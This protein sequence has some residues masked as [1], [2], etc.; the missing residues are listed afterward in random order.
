MRKSAR[1]SMDTPDHVF[2]SYVGS[3]AFSHSPGGGPLCNG[4]ESAPFLAMDLRSTSGWLGFLPTSRSCRLEYRLNH[5]H[6]LDRVL[7]RHRHLALTPY[8]PRKLIALNRILVDN[9]KLLHFR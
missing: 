8:R 6:V 4:T 9:R 2:L 5:R 7:Q 1:F 3:A